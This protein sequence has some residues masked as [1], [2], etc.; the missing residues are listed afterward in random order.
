MCQ[1]KYI[2][3]DQVAWTNGA[4]GK[5]ADGPFVGNPY[6]GGSLHEGDM[7]IC[8]PFSYV[9]EFE[10]NRPEFGGRIR[11]LPETALHSE[12]K[13][14]KGEHRQVASGDWETKRT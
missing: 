14:C 8:A 10:Q 9:V 5:I 12:W 6:R 1:P 4:R 7:Q 11:L 3:G 13:W 2:R